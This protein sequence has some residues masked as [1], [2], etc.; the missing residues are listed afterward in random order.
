M[1]RIPKAVFLLSLLSPALISCSDNGPGKDSSVGLSFAVLRASGIVA[2]PGFIVTDAAQRKIQIDQVQLV[3]ADIKLERLEAS[4]D[5][6][7]APAGCRDFEAGPILVSLP[8]SGGLMTVIT[9]PVP[10][11]RY[12]ELEFEIETPD[13]DNAQ[14]NAF[15]AVH[16][17]WPRTASIRIKGTYDSGTGAQPFDIFLNLDTSMDLKFD[18]A[19]EILPGT[20]GLNM[21]IAVDVSRWFRNPDGTLI[22]P[23]SINADSNFRG[24]VEDNIEN[25]FEAF[26]DPDRDGRDD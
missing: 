5:C 26:E 24:R 4:A 15:R 19:L 3:I 23:R 12:K 18:P 16:A 21:T 13:D 14:M 1:N 22:D 6:N 9:E 7:V 8:L 20:N 2:G 11:G 10:E 25:S 17:A